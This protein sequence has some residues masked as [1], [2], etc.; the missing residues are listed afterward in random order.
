MVTT[1]SKSRMPSPA[2]TPRTSSSQ[3][4]C[5]SNNNNEWMESPSQYSYN[6]ASSPRRWSMRLMKKEYLSK[7]RSGTT[8]NKKFL[9]YAVDWDAV[10]ALCALKNQ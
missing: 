7:T 3:W 2:T 10:H 1:R 8:Y 5:G 9:D 6:N 4:S